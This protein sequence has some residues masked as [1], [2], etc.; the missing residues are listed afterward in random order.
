MLNI[1]RVASIAVYLY[2]TILNVTAVPSPSPGAFI[3]NVVAIAVMSFL[4]F[5]LD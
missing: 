1:A 5:V 2:T 3:A 4:C